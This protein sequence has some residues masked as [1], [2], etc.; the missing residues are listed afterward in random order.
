MQEAAQKS[1][2]DTK[3]RKHQTP[4]ELQGNTREHE[5]QKT[6]HQPGGKPETPPADSGN[7]MQEAAQG[8]KGTPEEANGRKT[9]HQQ[10]GF[11]ER[12]AG[13]RS[14][15]PGNDR[16]PERQED[17]TPTRGKRKHQPGRLLEA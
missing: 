8:F 12:D 3:A 10:G 7:V 15:L 11:W 14:G 13:S 1:P 5:S 17:S 6:E 9:E 4:T 2:E 16:G